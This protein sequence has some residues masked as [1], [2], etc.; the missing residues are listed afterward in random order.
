MPPSLQGTREWVSTVKPLC[1]QASDRAPQEQEVLEDPAGQGHRV[2]AVLLAQEHAAVLDQRGD[3]VVEAG[4]DA[5]PAGTPARE[6]VDG[7]GDQVGAAREE[8][9]ARLDGGA[10]RQWPRRYAR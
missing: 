8:R 2:E 9:R 1:L 10:V 4:G 6:I 7:R 3:A 5:A